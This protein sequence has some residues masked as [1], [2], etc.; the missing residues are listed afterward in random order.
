MLMLCNVSFV[1]A[2][3]L[4]GRPMLTPMTA[5]VLL[6]K[7]QPPEWYPLLKRN[8]TFHTL[9][10]NQMPS[11]DKRPKDPAKSEANTKPRIVNG[12]GVEDYVPDRLL[13][14]HYVTHPTVMDVLGSQGEHSDSIPVTEVLRRV[15][16]TKENMQ[17]S[18]A[19]RVC[20]CAMSALLL[21]LVSFIAVSSIS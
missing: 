10:G 17:Y 20:D 21:L 3:D 9:D 19:I 15:V 18:S 7:E 13:S 1:S 6:G 12:T 4:Q 16:Y 8:V 11:N 2:E 14:L 5:E